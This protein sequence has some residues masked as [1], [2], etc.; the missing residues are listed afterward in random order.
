MTNNITD[1][2]SFKVAEDGTIIRVGEIET[3]KLNNSKIALWIF[4]I[5]AIIT[6]IGLGIILFVV[7]EDLTYY[8]QESYR[9]SNNLQN[10]VTE[11]QN[12]NTNLKNENLALRKQLPQTYKTRYANQYLF[13]KNCYSQYEKAN[14]YYQGS[15]VSIDIYNQEN[16]YGLTSD[17]YW[18]PMSCLEKY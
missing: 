13:N 9:I 10:E 6:S 11:L 16:G 2:S 15:G 3:K 14:C 5:L 17:G 7:N 1:N 18:I 12:E 4:L 8:Q